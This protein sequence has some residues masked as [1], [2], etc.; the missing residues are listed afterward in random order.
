MY[1]KFGFGRA[2]QD[3]GIDIRRG[4][5]SRDQGKM[6]AQMYDNCYPEPYIGR[7]LDYYGITMDEFNDTIDRFANK[8]L[9]YKDSDGRWMPKFEIV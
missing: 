3:S 7:Y 2:T 6:L 5:M 8:E 1:L 9:F 4:A